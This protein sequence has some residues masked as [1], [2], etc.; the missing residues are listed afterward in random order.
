MGGAVER[1]TASPGCRAIPLQPVTTERKGDNYDRH[2]SVDSRELRSLITEKGTLELSLI[3]VAVPTPTPDQVLMRVEAAPIN[4][5]DLGLLFAGA[6]MDSGDR[7][8]ARRIARS[9]RATH[10]GGA[11][12]ISA[13]RVGES[14]PVGNE[15]AGTVVAAGDFP[16]SPG[17]AG[18]TVAVAGGSMYAQYRMADAS[19]CL[20][21]AGRHVGKRRGVVVRQPAHRARDDRDDATEGHGASYTPRRRPTWARCSSSCASRRRFRS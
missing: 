2:R 6:D 20:V 12:G 5:S 17:T 10:R 4:P 9:S 21:L 3:D 19:A 1:F 16:E 14:L 7:S 18:R 11:P 13:A 15:G 8:P